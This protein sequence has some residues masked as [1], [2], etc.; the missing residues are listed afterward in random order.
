MSVECPT[1]EKK[2]FDRQR[3]AF[4]AAIRSSRGFGGGFRVYRCPCGKYHLTTSRK[5]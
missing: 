1:P 3:D 2:A 4:G 5:R